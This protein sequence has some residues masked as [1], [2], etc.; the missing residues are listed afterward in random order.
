MK[1]QLLV[2]VL[3]AQALSGCAALQDVGN[4]IFGTS[5]QKA[6][7]TPIW[8][9]KPDLQ[10]ILDG[11]T[12][13]GTA[14]SVISDSKDIQIQSQVSIDRVEISTCSRHDVCQ[15]KGGTLAC[16]PARFKVDT[17]WFGNAGKYMTYHFSPDK[18]EHDDSC[19][20]LEV[21]IFD[22]NQLAAWG[23]IVLRTDPAKNFA[24]HFTCNGT[25]WK[26]SGVSLCSV[27]AGTI[28]QINF[29]QP[30]DNFR[31]DQGCNIKKISDSEFEFQPAVGWC[32]ASFGRA[33]QYHDVILNGYDEVLIRDG[34]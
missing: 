4:V 22:K 1:H 10:I 19:A 17:D 34:G 2:W 25:D 29:D 33:L 32:R 21:S 23:Y 8:V 15:V 20:N 30:V 27:K 5:S 9:Y 7:R 28:Q 13:Y 3:V 12:F 6:T 26:F 18:K 14:V 31:A 16:D 11:E 24:A